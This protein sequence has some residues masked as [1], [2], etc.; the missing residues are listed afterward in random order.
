[1][2]AKEI[3]LNST[4]IGNKRKNNLMLNSRIFTLGIFSNSDNVNIVIK[5][6]VAC[7]RST[8]SYICIQ[9]EFSAKNHDINLTMPYTPITNIFDLG[10]SLPDSK[11]ERTMTFADRCRKR[12]LQANF[13]RMH[14]VYT[15]ATGTT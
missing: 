6:F 10:D 14:Q 11:I 7:E 15:S 4:A 8:R 5:R 9:I 2:F 3:D 12:T 1:M 13:V